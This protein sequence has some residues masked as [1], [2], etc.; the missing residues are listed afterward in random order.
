MTM[1]NFRRWRVT[2]TVLWRLLLAISLLLVTFALGRAQQPVPAPTDIAEADENDVAAQD[3]TSA[4]DQTSA[5]ATAVIEFLAETN[6]Q[7]PSE[8]LR[9]VLLLQPLEA[10]DEAKRYLA[11]LTGQNLDARWSSS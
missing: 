1:Q 8:L 4:V 7:T 2:N 11:R 9:A 5:A 6:P 3:Q 10:F